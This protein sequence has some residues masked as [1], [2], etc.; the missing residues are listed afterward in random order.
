MWPVLVPDPGENA[1][2]AARPSDLGV[3]AAPAADRRRS[4]RGREPVV[5]LRPTSRMPNR[6]PATTHKRMICAPD[7]G[8]NAA[9]IRRSESIRREGSLFFPH[10]L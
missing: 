3:A 8:W 9:A 6:Q 5:Q 2:A 4:R 10:A 1:E 7:A